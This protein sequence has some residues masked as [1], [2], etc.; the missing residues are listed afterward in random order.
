MDRGAQQLTAG[1]GSKDFFVSYSGADRAWAEWIAWVLEEAGYTVLLQAWDF[2]PGSNFVLEMQRAAAQAERTIA[3]FSPDFLASQFTA[4]EWAAAFRRDPTGARGLLLPVRVRECEPESL[5]AEIVYID[6]LGLEDKNAARDR[7][8]AGVKRERAKPASEPAFPASAAPPGRREIPEEPRFPGALPRVW[9]LPHRNP[10]FTGRQ[11]LI[12][13]LHRNLTARTATA[14]T[15]TA[16]IHGLGGVGKT[17]L[18]TEY[19]Y[20]FKGD[21]D[22]GWWLRAEDPA[23]LAGDCIALARGLQLDEKDAVEQAI[24]IA[25]VRRWLESHDRWLLIYDNAEDPKVVR[26]SLPRVLSGHVLITSRNP[27]WGGIAEMLPLDR[28]ERAES[29]AFLKERR[30]ESDDR[31]ADRV[32]EALGDL[33]LALEQVAAYCEQ[34]GTTL[35]G[36]ANLL[37]QGYGA[38]LWR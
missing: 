23:A 2:R 4:P 7:L 21:Y 13:Q 20:R 15:Q 19:A 28:W 6:L 14:L 16:A 8:L 34:T 32:A 27:A 18:A 33:P 3:V 38:E 17:D 26:E 29:I 11:E 30:Q 25:A 22:V 1:E 35:G 24:V 12:D 37:E 9:N 10:H 36:Y 5:L 31:A